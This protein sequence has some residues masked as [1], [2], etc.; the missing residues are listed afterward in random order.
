[1]AGG[2]ASTAPLKNIGGVSD[3]PAVV[4]MVSGVLEAA[5]EFRLVGSGV[6]RADGTVITA[7]HVLK[8]LPVPADRLCGNKYEIGVFRGANE[9]KFSL[10]EDIGWLKT[11]CRFQSTNIITQTQPPV[12]TK[13]AVSGFPVRSFQN[14]DTLREY[15]NI[16]PQVIEGELIPATGKLSLPDTNAMIMKIDG[17]WGKDIPGFSGGPCAYKNEDGEW[18]VFGILVRYFPDQHLVFFGRDTHILTG[19]RQA[20][21][22]IAPISKAL[23]SFHIE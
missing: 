5:P 6:P 11:G 22:V 14:H 23:D 15:Q 1:M 13:V 20:M 2:C 16:V 21:V 18:V 9:G 3:G 8:N 12:G 17:V 7:A 19:K 10:S 4:P